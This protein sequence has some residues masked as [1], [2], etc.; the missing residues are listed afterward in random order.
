MFVYQSNIMASREPM[1]NISHVPLNI[2]DSHT[3]DRIFRLHHAALCYYANRVIGSIDDA[4]DV[5]EEVFIKCWNSEK[6]FDS[7]EHVIFFLYKAVQN[8]SLNFI[9]SKQRANNKHDLAGKKYDDVE[10]SHL[11]RLIRAEVLREIYDEIENLPPQERNIMMLSIKE[12]RKNQEIAD[13]FGISL[14]SVKNSKSRALNRLRFKLSA[15]DFLL[16]SL[17]ISSRL[18]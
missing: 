11:E 18:R 7:N 9:K 8:A 16:L 5:V 13:E 12:G 14:Q 10:E 1:D 4:E 17:I 3:F 6:V 15:E 2:S